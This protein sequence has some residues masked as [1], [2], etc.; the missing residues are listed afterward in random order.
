MPPDLLRSIDCHA[1]AAP[2]RPAL[3]GSDGRALSY[4][5]LRR[6]LACRRQALEDAGLSRRTRIAVLLPN[7]E[8]AALEILSVL[9]HATCIPLN[10]AI[11][12]EALRHQLAIC[13][14]GALLHAADAPDFVRRA[15]IDLGLGSIAASADRT[16]VERP[17]IVRP[18]VADVGPAPA[19]DTPALV[20]QTSGTTGSPKRVPLSLANLGW[21]ARAIA[22]HLALG[23]SDRAL[24]LLPL[25]HVHGLVGSVLAPLVAGGSVVCTAG[26]EHGRFVQW[27][28]DLAPTWYT[29]TPAIHLA[30][31]RAMQESDAAPPSALRFVR[32]SSSALAPAVIAQLER[33]FRV[34][35]IEAYGATETSSPICSNPMPPGLR[36]PGSVGLPCGTEVAIVGSDGK[37]LATGERG[38]VVVRGPGVMA[39]YEDDADHPPTTDRDGGVGPVADGWLRTGDLGHL[40]ADGYLHVDGRLKEQINKGG[41]KVSPREIDDALLALEGIA[42][43]ACFAIPHPTLGE[44]IAAAVVLAPGSPLDAASILVLLQSRLDPPKVPTIVHFVERL[45]RNTGGKVLRH[46]LGARRWPDA[47]SAGAPVAPAD[48]LTARLTGLWQDVLG[49]AAP[50][51]DAD[52]FASGGDSLQAARLVAQ[53]NAAFDLDLTVDAVFLDR[54]IATLCARIRSGIDA[55]RAHRADA[56]SPDASPRFDDV[57]AMTDEEV[58]RELAALEAMSDDEVDAMPNRSAHVDA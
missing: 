24:N 41:E 57:D 12:A 29:A 38:E 1:D 13:R 28:H 34:P 27:L 47:P 7:G 55:T 10:P 37:R 31:L 33:R 23:P 42:E 35:V 40:D 39:G 2:D 17:W 49:G 45:P 51:P 26:F 36:K 3:L 19:S 18:P 8:H 50:R 53:I 20:L 54:R 6:A 30:A 21:S 56:A 9:T 46:E 14:A 11:G 15:A 44:D 4:A 58:E 5:A 22:R 43:A 52:F 48:A 32:S 25:F 16:D